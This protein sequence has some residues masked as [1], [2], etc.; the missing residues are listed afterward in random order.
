VKFGRGEEAKVFCRTGRQ[1]PKM[2]GI[3]GGQESA[4][5]DF[6]SY[7]KVQ[8]LPY[9]K[10]PSSSA[11]KTCIKRARSLWGFHQVLKNSVKISVDWSRAA[12]TYE[13]KPCGALH[14]D[15]GSEQ[16]SVY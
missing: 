6:T 8:F 16:I 15:T 1:Q 14:W 5:R 2:S 4:N 7:S 3:S 10:R 13:H 12:E 9:S 11:K